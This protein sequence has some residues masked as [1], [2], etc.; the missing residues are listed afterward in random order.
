M[1]RARDLRRPTRRYSVDCRRTSARRRRARST[2]A[3]RYP[4]IPGAQNLQGVLP[5]CRPAD[6]SGGCA[7]TG[8]A[9]ATFHDRKPGGP[10]KLRGRCRRC[11]LQRRSRDVTRRRIEDRNV[12]PDRAST[13]FPSMKS[14]W[15]PSDTFGQKPGARSRSDVQAEPC[16]EFLTRIVANLSDGSSESTLS[17]PR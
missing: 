5:F 11:R 4:G 1:G 16:V 2:A 9:C 8:G 13:N 14:S 6:R 7:A 10:P 17:G 15:R 12:F 3:S